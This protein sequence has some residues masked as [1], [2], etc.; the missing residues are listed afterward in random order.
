MKTYKDIQYQL[1]RSERKTASIYI[2][3]NGEVSLLV[4]NGLDDQQV[5][6]LIEGKLRWI[7]KGLAE[8]R[9]LNATQVHLS[10][11]HI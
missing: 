7:Y 3:R 9:D 8:W 11:I 4:P 6:G 10:L 2:E 1:T 5:E